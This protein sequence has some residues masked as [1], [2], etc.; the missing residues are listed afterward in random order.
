MTF[1]CVMLTPPCGPARARAENLTDR[2][3]SVCSGYIANANRA[4]PFFLICAGHE[5]TCVDS[6]QTKSARVTFVSC[7]SLNLMFIGLKVWLRAVLRL[8]T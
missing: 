3:F 5:K 1:L 8:R 7:S 4:T 6:L 2:N